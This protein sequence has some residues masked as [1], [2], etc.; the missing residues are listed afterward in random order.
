MILDLP[1]L[2]VNSF[3]VLLNLLNLILAVRHVHLLIRFSAFQLK[4][5]IIQLI[6]DSVCLNLQLLDVCVH[7]LNNK[8]LLILELLD[9]QVADIL[10][11]LQIFLL[12]LDVSL[13]VLNLDVILLLE[14]LALEVN[15]F[16]V[17]DV[18]I[19]LILLLQ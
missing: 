10:Q 7:L 5:D 8:L 12:L 14:V 1:Q 9:L 11:L 13:H 4:N 19:V 2:L 16:L 18:S 6:L 17:L 3:Y 15:C